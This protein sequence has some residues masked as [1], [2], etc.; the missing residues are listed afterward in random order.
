MSSTQISTLW[1]D[2]SVLQLT[3][4]ESRSAIPLVGELHRIREDVEQG[5]LQLGRPIQRTTPRRQ[6]PVAG[7]DGVHGGTR[8]GSIGA[9]RQVLCRPPLHTG[10][11]SLRGE[12][13]GPSTVHPRGR[14]ETNVLRDLPS[15]SS[16]APF[17]AMAHPA[18]ATL[19]RRH[20]PCPC[21]LLADPPATWRSPPWCERTTGRSHP[22]RVTARCSDVF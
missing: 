5:L 13:D 18:D 16:S 22:P 4:N 11:L 17:C 9:I 21:T 12:R 8:C 2:A 1:P 20:A 15:L 3:P 19:D 6:L 7:E 14:D 10:T